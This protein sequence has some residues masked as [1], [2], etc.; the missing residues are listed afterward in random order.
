MG[1]RLGYVLVFSKSKDLV[2]AC[3]DMLGNR[4]TNQGVLAKYQKKAPLS[5]LEVIPKSQ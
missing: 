3:P 5:L 1:S 4:D 2:A